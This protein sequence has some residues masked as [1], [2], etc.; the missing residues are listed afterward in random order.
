MGPTA[1]L[2]GATYTTID[3]NEPAQDALQDVLEA[4]LETEENTTRKQAH[5]NRLAQEL[6]ELGC[7]DVQIRDQIR[8]AAESAAVD[9]L[10][11]APPRKDSDKEVFGND[12]G[13]GKWKLL[14]KSGTAVVMDYNIFHRGCRR[15]P[16]GLW[17][18]MFKLQFFRTTAPSSWACAELPVIPRP[19]KHSGEPKSKQAIWQALW[20][21]MTGKRSIGDQSA[22]AALLASGDEVQF[23]PVQ[24][25]RFMLLG[26]HE[27]KHPSAL[28]GAGHY[29]GT[30]GAELASR[31]RPSWCW[32]RTRFTSC[33]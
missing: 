22:V 28:Y 2:P 5:N 32:L 3:H 8:G 21:W 6:K 11:A 27:S 29:V 10:G 23:L 13:A 17:R 7:S 25:F 30:N 14:C 12:F 20:C 16:G 24:P 15:M 9:M 33:R 4:Y 18:A 19:F 1:I 31:Y 26:A